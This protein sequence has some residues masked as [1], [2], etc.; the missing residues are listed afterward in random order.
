[1]IIIHV[2]Y[3]LMFY[4]AHGAYSGSGSSCRNLERV[5]LVSES[6][7]YRG[8][9]CLHSC[10]FLNLCAY[11]VISSI[12]SLKDQIVGAGMIKSGT[13]GNNIVGSSHSPVCLV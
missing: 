4:T 11:R 7:V 9:I 10:W 6:T 1:M 13:P 12:L 5:V 2:Y 3:N 8:D